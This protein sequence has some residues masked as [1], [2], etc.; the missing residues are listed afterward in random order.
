MLPMMQATK[1]PKAGPAGPMYV[2]VGLTVTTS[3]VLASN[4]PAPSMD[5]MMTIEKNRESIFQGESCETT[6]R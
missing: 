6:A 1:R 3:E 2:A 5:N 4:A